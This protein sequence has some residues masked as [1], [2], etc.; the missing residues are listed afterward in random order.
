MIDRVILDDQHG[1]LLRTAL[2]HATDTP[3]HGARLA[4]LHRQIELHIE[5]E[6]AAVPRR[7][8][9]AQG[10]AEQVNQ[11]PADGQAN[12]QPPVLTGHRAIQLLEALIE[13]ATSWHAEADAAV[14]YLDAQWHIGRERAAGTDAQGHMALVGELD[15]VIEQV[16]DALRQLA[17]IALQ[18]IRQAVIEFDDEFQPL[19]RGARRILGAQTIE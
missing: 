3:T 4:H 6:A 11:L 18:S 10:T 1:A 7:G 2:R 14:E 8:M 12:T 16:T 5:L 17:G 9:M 15:R 13:V 19:F